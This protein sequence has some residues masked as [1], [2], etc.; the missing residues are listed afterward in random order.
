MVLWSVTAPKEQKAVQIGGRV[1]L[2]MQFITCSHLPSQEVSY[3]RVLFILPVTKLAPFV[4]LRLLF[5]WEGF[6]KMETLRIRMDGA[7]SN[8]I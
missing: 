4:G 3:C 8:L 1:W 5:K 6:V 7:L 2:F